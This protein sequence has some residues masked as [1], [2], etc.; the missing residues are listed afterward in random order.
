MFGRAAI[1]LSID[2][3]SSCLILLLDRYIFRFP[4]ISRISSVLL[5]LRYPRAVRAMLLS[6]R[7]SQTGIVSN[8]L[9]GSSS[10]LA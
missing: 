5:A 3:H 9:K 1:T 7:P 2:P 4:A 10:F 8:R 6:D